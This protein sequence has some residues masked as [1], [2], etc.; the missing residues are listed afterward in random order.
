M[1]TA[2]KDGAIKHVMADRRNPQGQKSIVLNNLSVEEL[3]HDYLWRARS[4][5]S[6]NGDRSGY[7]TDQIMKKIL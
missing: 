5:I 7:I 4:C 1:D 2:G 3:S 6:R